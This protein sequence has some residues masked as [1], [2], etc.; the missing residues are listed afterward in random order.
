MAVRLAIGAGRWRLIRLV[1]GESL[2]LSMAG[3]LAGVA[4][5]QALS[6]ELLAY[7]NISLDFKLDWRLFAFLLGISLLTSL[8]FG[9]AAALRASR[10]PPGA[11]MKAGGHGMTASRG[12]LGFRGALVV[13]QVALSLVLL[14]IALLFTQSLRNSADR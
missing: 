9:L 1:L 11:A 7:L 14:F 10:T 3:A 4:L 8:L 6:R 12:R 5:A 2:L 13:A